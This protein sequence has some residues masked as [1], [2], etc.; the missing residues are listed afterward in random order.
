MTVALV[1]GT[2][3]GIGQATALHLAR[4]GFHVHAGLRTVESG[5][6]LLKLARAESLGITPIVLD[7]NNDDSVH[8]GVQGVLDATGGIDVLVNNAGIGGG[9]AIE[10]VPL[11]FAK[12]VFET[13][14][15]GA[16]RMIRAVPLNYLVGRAGLEP[17]T[18]GLKARRSTH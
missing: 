16:I 17:A 10:D 4:R 9:G 5:A 6:E 11:D 1:T 18:P 8:Q 7:V 13:N 3:T 12:R 2:T 15:F 14:Y